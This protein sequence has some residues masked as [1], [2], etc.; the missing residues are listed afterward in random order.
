M[1]RVL[2][3]IV[4]FLMGQESCSG[5]GGGGGFGGGGSNYSGGD[6]TGSSGGGGGGNTGDCDPE[7]VS[8]SVTCEFGNVFTYTAEMS[9]PVT[10]I[11]V[12]I[13]DTDEGIQI[14]EK[15]GTGVF[16][17]EYKTPTY[18]CKDAMPIAFQAFGTMASTYECDYDYVP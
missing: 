5:G 14:T 4:P 13:N 15:G 11:D 3:C 12:K 10:F 9:E 18:N 17:G 6:D 1:W 7:F 2:V 8:V 16:E